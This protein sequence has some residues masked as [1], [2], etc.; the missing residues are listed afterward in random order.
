MIACDASSIVCEKRSFG[1]DKNRNNGTFTV[2]VIMRSRKGVHI[3][4]SKLFF[5]VLRA[6]FPQNTTLRMEEITSLYFRI[7]QH[8]PENIQLQAAIDSLVRAVQESPVLNPPRQGHPISERKLRQRLKAMLS[9][10]FFFQGNN[11]GDGNGK[12]RNVS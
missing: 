12:L 4:F 7:Q 9:S 11:Y 3:G 6:T 8:S 10:A 1:E 5:A 2:T